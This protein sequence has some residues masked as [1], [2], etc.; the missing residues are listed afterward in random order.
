MC[1]Y[2]APLFLLCGLASRASGQGNPP[3]PVYLLGKA[4]GVM[5]AQIS[6]PGWLQDQATFDVT[7][8]IPASLPKD[9]VHQIPL[10][11]RSMLQERFKLA[12]HVDQKTMPAYALVV[13][14]KGLKMQ[15]AATGDTTDQGC[16]SAYL[17]GGSNATSTWPIL[18]S[19]FKESFRNRC[20]WWIELVFPA[21]TISS[22]PGLDEPC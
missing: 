18:Q 14:P 19:T 16:V 7:A 1:G 10:M 22:S 21:S 17:Q 15:P 20:R 12:V 8:K 11:L 13:D 2:A 4:Y 5:D 9:R 6:G 3:S